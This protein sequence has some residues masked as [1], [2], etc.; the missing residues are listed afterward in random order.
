M[1]RNPE[2]DLSGNGCNTVFLNSWGVE[3][4]ICGGRMRFEIKIRYKYE[5]KHIKDAGFLVE[6][7]KEIYSTYTREISDR[8]FS[9]LSEET[10]KHY[11]TF[12]SEKYWHWTRNNIQTNIEDSTLISFNVD[13]SI[14]YHEFKYHINI[15]SMKELMKLVEI[16]G[17]VCV[18]ENFVIKLLK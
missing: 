5:L 1:Y 16:F 2:G 10:K 15:H 17:D 8:D 4:N 3:N 6:K 12:T 9:E 7:T 11:H 14:N 18:N 13:G